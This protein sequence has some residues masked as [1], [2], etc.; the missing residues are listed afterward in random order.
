MNNSIAPCTIKTVTLQANETFV[1]PPGA[2]LIFATDSSLITVSP[3][4]CTP[5][6]NLE[7]L[8]CYAYRFSGQRGSANNRTENWEK[9]SGGNFYVNGIVVND[10]YYPFTSPIQGWDPTTQ[11]FQDAINTVTQYS[12]ILNVYYS[13]YSEDSR[14]SNGGSGW[15]NVV[16]I[17]TI[18]SIANTLLFKISTVVQNQ[19]SVNGGSS[20][21]AYVK[22][23]VTDCPAPPPTN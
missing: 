21:E 17:K 4:E 15:T 8:K 5:T 19:D 12:G 13:D 3:V 9:Y 11:N 1:L 23:D 10:V 7:T 2:E 22:G 20:T 16:Y 14:Q 6:D 18:P